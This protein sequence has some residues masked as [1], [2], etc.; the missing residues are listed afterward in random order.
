MGKFFEKTVAGI[1]SLLLQVIFT[2]EVSQKKGYLQSLDPRVK[3][4]SL[5]ILLLTVNLVH[6]FLSL[7]LIY[8]FILFLAI[9][10]SIPMKFFLK[11]VWLF[12]PF[13]TGII[14]FPLIFNIVTPGTTLLELVNLPALHINLSITVPGLLTAFN[15]IFRVAVSVSLVVLAVLSTP[16]YDLLKSLQVLFVPQVF[17]VILGMTYRYIFVLLQTVNNMFLSRKSRLAGRVSGREN[18]KWLASL[19]GTLFARSFV[20]S[21]EIYLSMQSRG[22]RNKIVTLD[23]FKL[24]SHDLLF[25]SGCLILCVNI[26]LFVK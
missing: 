2:Q 4:I 10:S 8:V 15:I 6:K 25:F 1:G 13:F 12:L 3:V 26:I 19:I 18:R 9:V 24:E 17:V 16:W 14:V 11:R 7:V 22:Y 5:I 23:S 21:E 20:Q